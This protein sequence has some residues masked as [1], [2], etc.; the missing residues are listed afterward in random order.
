M[1]P[2]LRRGWLA[3]LFFV[4]TAAAA[5][6]AL[7]GSEQLLFALKKV[8]PCCVID[9]R[10]DEARRQH[11][12]ADA[13][14]YRPGMTINPTASVVVVAEN[15]RTAMQIGKALAKAHPGKT[16]IA[17]KGGVSAWEA[18]LASTATSTASGAAGFD[19]VIP[20]NTCETG[21]PL[22]QLRSNPK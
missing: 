13:L 20:H 1:K 4:A 16:I 15:D 8:P 22:Q 19:F 9:G 21:A 2:N 10:S 6:V 17:V 11:P 7:R 14:P 18:V 3:A 12:L 5:E